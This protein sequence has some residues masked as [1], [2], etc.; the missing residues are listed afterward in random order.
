MI[1]KVS[2]HTSHRY[3]KCKLEDEGLY[4]NGE[5][6]RNE[7]TLLDQNTGSTRTKRNRVTSVGMVHGCTLLREE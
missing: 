3:D 6:R 1:A 5:H 4:L 7:I 2:T